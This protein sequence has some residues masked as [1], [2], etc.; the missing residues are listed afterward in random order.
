MRT[1]F[2]NLLIDCEKF[3][4][5]SIVLKYPYF[6]RMKMALLY[7]IV[8]VFCLPN[9]SWG[10][11]DPGS[12]SIFLQVII[13]FVIGG[14]ISFRTMIFNKLKYISNLFVAKKK[15]DYEKKSAKNKN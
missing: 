9:C 14:L 15:L 3:F 13:A 6:R 8:F 1:I 2:Y 12:I 5:I 4:K 10:Y 7:F 11:V